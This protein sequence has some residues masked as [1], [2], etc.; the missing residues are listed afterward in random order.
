MTSPPP[1]LEKQ[2]VRELESWIFRTELRN[3]FPRSI[4]GCRALP[5]N[6]Y[7]MHATSQTRTHRTFRLR[8]DRSMQQRWK[9]RGR[10]WRRTMEPLQQPDVEHIM[11]AGAWR[12]G[13]TDRDVVDQLGDAVGPEETWLE[14][15]GD[16]LGK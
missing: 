14:L 10:V 7:L 16:R 12:Q 4:G 5:V 11:D 6:E 2:L 9:R 3:I 1:P 13:E 15:A 8:N